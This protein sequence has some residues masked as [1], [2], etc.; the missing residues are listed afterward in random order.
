MKIDL[1]HLILVLMVMVNNVTALEDA[2]V[3]FSLRIV[4][5]IIY[6]V[7][8]L[9]VG[10]CWYDILIQKDK[11]LPPD[12]RIMTKEMKC[13][14]WVMCICFHLFGGLLFLCILKAEINKRLKRID[15]LQAANQVPIGVAEGGRTEKEGEV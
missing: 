1:R 15:M 11:K 7:A 4:V 9:L 8:H 2:V 3:L 10:Y 13:T 5:F 14:F 6:A 12:E